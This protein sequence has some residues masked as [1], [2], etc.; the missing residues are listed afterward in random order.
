MSSPPRLRRSPKRRAL[1]ERSNSHANEIA[2]PTLRVVGDSDAKIYASTPFPTTESQV[3][4]PRGRRAF[5]QGVSVSAT[6]QPTAATL[7]TPRTPSPIKAPDH[8]KLHSLA[9]DGPDSE[10]SQTDPE[11]PS[12]HLA[13]KPSQTTESPSTI[14]VDRLDMDG[15]IVHD[16]ERASDEIIQL[17]SVDG[18]RLDRG[19]SLNP[20]SNSSNN[21]HRASLRAIASV[22]S[23][24]S[25]DSTGSSDTVV[26]RAVQGPP[27]RGSY[28]LFPPQPRPGSS[29]STGSTPPRFPDVETT[30][31]SLSPVSSTSPTSPVSPLSPESPHFPV[32]PSRVYQPASHAGSDTTVH[33]A[34][35]TVQYPVI[36]VP[37]VSGS[38]AG[39][40]F[41]IPRRPVG[42]IEPTADESRNSHL[43][44]IHS[45]GT[46]ERS[47][48]GERNRGTI[49]S[50]LRSSVAV[51]GSSISSYYPPIPPQPVFGRSREVTS[52]SIRVVNE[53]GDE[54]STLPSPIRR[55]RGFYD[56]PLANRDS[57]RNS[58][59]NASR[60]GAGSRG[61]F[62]KDSIPAWAR[63][64]R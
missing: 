17:P 45:E 60:A 24:L 12:S 38:F 48:A 3:L 9:Y 59:Y 32:P 51:D 2:A 26:R 35:H 34:Q 13:K 23:Q 52:S 61:S 44:T 11:S 19:R 5:D 37:G 29:R 36:R 4:S 46:N 30:R 31:I 1:H 25:L 40:H 49:V 7:Q 16:D 62:L 55:G 42:M 54:V 41:R 18:S 58:R 20:A 64:V 50:S 14:G 53:E 6:S 21:D 57:W 28:A 56:P 27:P 10:L 47:S 33:E 15:G 43:S 8:G 22:A 63:Y 39:S